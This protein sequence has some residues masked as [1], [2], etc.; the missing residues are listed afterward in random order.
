MSVKKTAPLTGSQTFQKET[1]LIT[2][3]K[4]FYGWWI[5]AAGTAV[6]FVSSG[7][8]FYRHGVIL[9]PLRT[10]QEWS[11]PTESSANTL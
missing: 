7:I 4:T 3:P 1:A 8:G 11:K 5:V 6:L 2:V 9:D 10:Q